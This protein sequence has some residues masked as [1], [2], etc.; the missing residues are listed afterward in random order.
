MRSDSG[1]LKGRLSGTIA[2]PAHFPDAHAHASELLAIAEAGFE[3]GCAP[4]PLPTS[5]AW[6][7]G[8]PAVYG[9]AADFGRDVYEPQRTALAGTRRSPGK[10][11]GILP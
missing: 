1:I 7:E 3:A 8:G 2:M 4:V 6:A 11:C 9:V 10:N 5:I